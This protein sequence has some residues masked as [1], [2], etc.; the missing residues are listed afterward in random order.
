MNNEVFDLQDAIPV[1]EEV[2]AGGG[3][4]RLYP[5]GTSMLPLIVE[6]RDSVVLKRATD[7][8]IQKHDIV[9]YKRDDGHFVLHRL[10]RFEKDGSFTLCGDHQLSFEKGI[11]TDQ[12]I[13]YVSSFYQGEKRIDCSSA[14]YRFYVILWCCMPLRRVAFFMRRMLSVFTRKRKGNTKG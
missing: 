11:R 1:I 6:G 4:F 14:R 13:A 9:F 3:E 2:L 7:R 10:M 8:S 12:I 5:K